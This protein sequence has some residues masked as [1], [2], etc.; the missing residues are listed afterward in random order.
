MG[1]VNYIFI[2]ILLSVKFWN[3]NPIGSMISGDAIMILTL[4]FLIYGY[5]KYR[6]ESTLSLWSPELKLWRYM[7]LGVVLSMIPAYLFYSQ[8]LKIS[9]MTYR[10][11]VLWFVIPVMMRVSPSLDELQM[12]FKRLMICLFCIYLCKMFF[13]GMFYIEER[14]LEIMEFLESDEISFLGYIFMSTLMFI[15]FQK[16]KDYFTFDTFSLCFLAYVVIFLASNRSTLFPMT[17]LFGFTLFY[18]RSRYK[19]PLLLVL[20][21]MFIF[22]AIYTSEI[23]SSLIDETT[24]QMDDSEYNRNKAYE[25][26]ISPLAHPSWLTYLLGNGFLSSHTTSLKADLMEIG[27]YNSDLGLVGFWHEFGIIPI[28]TI[29]I[30]IFIPLVR[31][32]NYSWCIKM[33]ALFLIAISLTLAYYGSFMMKL[34]YTFYYYLLFNDK[35]LQQDEILSDNT[36]LQG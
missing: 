15:C 11:N 14:K 30:T 23:W 4:L 16:M 29:I 13:P 33:Y 9:I 27:I 19:L 31:W 22:A 17:L 36:S 2:L 1:K 8:S 20:A 21:I 34:F 7:V 24:T 26:F 12:V 5:V 3:I 25:Y 18:I 28:A 35:K 10:A 32:N 6:N